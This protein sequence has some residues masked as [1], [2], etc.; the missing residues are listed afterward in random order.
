MASR[1]EKLRRRQ[2]RKDKNRRQALLREADPMAATTR[3]VVD[4]PSGAVKMS[5]VLWALVEP[6]CSGDED[7]EQLGKLLTLGVAAWNAG[8]VQGKKRAEFVDR[9]AQGF[10]IELRPD[11]KRVIEPLV[12]R[13]EELFPHIQRAI[14]SFE[15]TWTTGKPHLSVL[16]DFG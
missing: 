13:K 9:V 12:R 14:I 8:L 5:E 1:A 3:V 7:E 11:F 15:L 10:P 4:A 2:H 16:S 6:E